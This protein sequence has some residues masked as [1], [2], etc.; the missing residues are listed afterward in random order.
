[1]KYMTKENLTINQSNGIVFI[2][3]NYIWIRRFFFPI[4]IVP[5]FRDNEPSCIAIAASR[6]FGN[7]KTS[8]GAENIDFD[9]L[10][11]TPEKVEETLRRKIL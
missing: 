5:F 2:R 3:I 7:I 4:T 9:I 1:M 10:I 8:E 11:T 6:R